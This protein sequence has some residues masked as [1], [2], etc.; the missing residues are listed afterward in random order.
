VK[1]AGWMV[2]AAKTT[3]AAESAGCLACAVH[4]CCVD[5]VLPCGD[6]PA[7]CSGLKGKS[8]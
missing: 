7:C 4:K 1:Q 3:S 2:V 8:I 6:R 5:V